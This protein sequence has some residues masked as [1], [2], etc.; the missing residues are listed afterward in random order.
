MVTVHLVIW[1]LK[2]QDRT[3][4]LNGSRGSA[5]TQMSSVKFITLQNGR[6]EKLDLNDNQ[7]CYLIFE[8]KVIY[9]TL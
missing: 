8:L 5:L 1:F 6:E 9:I 3:V 4:A 2:T 7:D